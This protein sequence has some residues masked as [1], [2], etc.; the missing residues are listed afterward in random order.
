MAEQVSWLMI[1]SGWEVVDRTGSA[2][3]EVTRV[4]GD[5]DADIFGGLRFAAA[6]EEERYVRAELVGEI[7]ERRVALE[8]GLAELERS[9]A[10]EEPGG[11]E[12][13]RDRDAE[14]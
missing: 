5:A 6:G 3:G 14:L 8:A 7:T 2:V 12:L 13:R 10:S 4:V 11:V 9:P 1:E